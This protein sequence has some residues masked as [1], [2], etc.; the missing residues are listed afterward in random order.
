MKT[1]STRAVLGRIRPGLLFCGVLGA[2]I[3]LVPSRGQACK[4]APPPS[5]TEA[6][7]QASAV[8]EASVTQLVPGSDENEVTLRVTRAWKGVSTETVRVRTRSDAAACGVAFEIGRSYLVYA[9]QSAQADTSIPLEVLRC[10]RTQPTEEAESDIV[11]LGLGVVPVAAQD[12]EAT[13]E[14]PAQ[15]AP[16]APAAGGCGGCAAAQRSPA[17]DTFYWTLGLALLAWATARKSRG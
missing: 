17:S 2:A 8:F 1:L 10:G 5:A 4:C 9:N 14:Q 7:Q 16:V 6:L 15:P 11:Q 13:S 3:W 12:P